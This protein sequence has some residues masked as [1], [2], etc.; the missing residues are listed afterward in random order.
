MFLAIKKMNWE[1][2]E[3]KEPKGQQELKLKILLNEMAE[4]S[5]STYAESFIN[6]FSSLIMD[7]PKTNNFS[8]NL[9]FAA[10]EINLK[11]IGIFKKSVLGDLKTKMYTLKYIGK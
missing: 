7:I 1:I 2:I 6:H 4:Y 3:H 8:A 10:V 5:Y 11:T 9:M